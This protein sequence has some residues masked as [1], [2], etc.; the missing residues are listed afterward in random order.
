MTPSVK[1]IESTSYIRTIVMASMFAAM[2]CIATMVI[3]IPTFV[4]NGYVNIGDTIVLLSAWLLTN[5]YGALAAGVGSMLADIL[6]GYVSYAPATFVI[7]F[8]MA[9]VC[10]A[11]FKKMS[12][13][14]L[15]V[16]ASYIITSVIAEII[17]IAGYFLYES[18]ILGY[19]LAAAASIISNAVQAVVC[20]LLGNVLI[21]VLP[22]VLKNKG[23][24]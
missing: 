10:A 19:G 15:P 11:S 18:T 6:S 2:T 14:R 24:Q 20:A 3:R 9:F 16:F 4:T 22:K 8:I 7:K 12:K 13:G 5:P 1:K 17:M 21:H 23:L